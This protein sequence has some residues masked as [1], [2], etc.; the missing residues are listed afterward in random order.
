MLVAVV[1]LQLGSRIEMRA[2]LPAFEVVVLHELRSSESGQRPAPWSTPRRW[3][4]TGK[5]AEDVPTTT[6]NSG[7]GSALQQPELGTKLSCKRST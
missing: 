4:P 6:S 7:T 1:P 2:T 5:L 3:S